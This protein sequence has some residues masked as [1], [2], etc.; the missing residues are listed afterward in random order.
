MP[1]KNASRYPARRSICARARRFYV[2][3]KQGF[4]L[5]RKGTNGFTCLVN[6]DAFVYGGDQF[7]PTCWDA[8]GATTF[9]PVM[10]KVGEMLA[11]KE[12]PDAIQKT[13]DAGFADKT[14][15][16]PGKG[17]VAYML[18][19]DV[20]IDPAN[21]HCDSHGLPG[22]YMFYANGATSE[23]LGTTR[24]AARNDPSLRGVFAGGAGGSHG[25][26]YI[27]AMPGSAHGGG[28][29]N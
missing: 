29:E 2:Y 12:S 24:E 14:F 23:Q 13:I 9:V 7:K 15:R 22:H 16:A 25:L 3:G 26:A 6:R 4:E 11:R 18:A 21:G 28:H 10:L 19:G 5:A 8:Q 27:I 1:P 20:D 17:G